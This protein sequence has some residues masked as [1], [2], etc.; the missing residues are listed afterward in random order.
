MKTNSISEIASKNFIKLN[1]FQEEEVTGE[2]KD[3]GGN[4]RFIPVVTDA[5]DPKEEVICLLQLAAEIEHLL[6]IQYLY[7]GYSIDESDN[8]IQFSLM[9]IAIQEMGH[10]LGVQNL[11]L[12]I[13]GIEELHLHKS[14]IRTKIE[15]HLLPFTLEPLTQWLLAKYVAVEAP[16]DVILQDPKIQKIRELAIEKAGVSFNPVGGIY[17]KIF[18]I[19]Q[20][21]DTVP[22]PEMM[23]LYAD[24]IFISGWHLKEED[25]VSLS[26]IQKFESENTDWVKGSMQAA[27]NSREVIFSQL[28]LGKDI[29]FQ[30]LKLVNDIA[31]QGERVDNVDT[32]NSHFEMFLHAYD[33]FMTAPPKVLNIPVNPV[34]VD[35]DEFTT[36]TKIKNKYTVLWAQLSNDLY[37]SLLLDIHGSIFYKQFDKAIATALVNLIKTNMAT[38]L[39]KITKKFLYKLPLN[40][41][42]FVY[43]G[44]PRSATPFEIADDFILPTTKAKADEVNKGIINSIR[45]KIKSIIDHPDYQTHLSFDQEAEDFLDTIEKRYCSIKEKKLSLNQ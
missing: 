4:E 8:E 40:D 36:S 44:I 26:E 5:K 10:L 19:L 38:L 15:F 7:T 30:C 45:Q 20:K 2:G 6:L 14:K 16:I 22:D 25:F 9:K 39:N 24:D 33:L 32:S 3:I 17:E 34:T 31:V 43:D 21:D 35:N 42:G 41:T 28:E 1:L 12:R 27:M 23:E 29:R 11:L 18:W 37:T 13:G